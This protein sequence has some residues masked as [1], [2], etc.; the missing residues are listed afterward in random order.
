[1]HRLDV[2]CFSIKY[3]KSKSSVRKMGKSKGKEI[4]ELSD[5]V[6]GNRKKTKDRVQTLEKAKSVTEF[7]VGPRRHGLQY[8]TRK[9]TTY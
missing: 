1:M 5:F 8:M 6:R 4:K 3:R 9:V 7:I 2:E